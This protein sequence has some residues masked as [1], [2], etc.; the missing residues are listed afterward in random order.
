M[1]FRY[2]LIGI[3]TAMLAILGVT[4]FNNLFEASEI[5]GQIESQGNKSPE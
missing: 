4:A 2:L 3:L 5:N 1:T